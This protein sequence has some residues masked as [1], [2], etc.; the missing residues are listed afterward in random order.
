MARRFRFQE[1]LI[2][3]LS[4]L[5]GVSHTIKSLLSGAYNPGLVTGVIVFVPIGLLL[6]SRMKPWMTGAK[7]VSAILVGLVVQAVVSI[8]ALTGGRL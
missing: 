1:W 6:L 2:V 5:A 3:L 8:L 7:F 4:G